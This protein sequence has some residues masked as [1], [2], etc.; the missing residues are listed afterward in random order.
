MIKRVCKILP[1]PPGG[2]F[3]LFF[4]AFGVRIL[5]GSNRWGW[6]LM[7]GTCDHCKLEPP[8]SVNHWEFLTS[9]AIIIFLTSGLLSEVT[10]IIHN[11]HYFTTK[12]IKCL[13]YRGGRSPS[14]ALSECLVNIP[15]LVLEFS[16]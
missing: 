7:P 5:T 8:G 9:R 13:I 14:L 12:L 4:P 15:K 16:I 2:R 3:V 1:R 6:G 11:K 10:L